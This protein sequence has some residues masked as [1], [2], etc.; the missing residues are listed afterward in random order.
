[1]KGS[2]SERIAMPMPRS[3]VDAIDDYRYSARIPSR[4]EAIRQV[5]EAAL[6][7]LR[8]RNRAA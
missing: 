7:A 6:K 2:N 8:H 3:L 5:L 1:M 4:A